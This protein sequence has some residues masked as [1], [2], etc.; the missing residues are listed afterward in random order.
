MDT[1]QSVPEEAKKSI[2]RSLR[3]SVLPVKTSDNVVVK[4]LKNTGFGVFLIM[5]SVVSLLMATAVAF[6]L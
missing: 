4:F 3:E 2:Y 6:A 1:E 5:L